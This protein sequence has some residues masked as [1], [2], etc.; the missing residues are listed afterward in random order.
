MTEQKD[1]KRIF[2]L[3]EERPA[4][5]IT[6][7][8]LPL[9]CGMF[10]MVLYNLVDTFFI[11]LLHDD[12]QMAAVNLAY[13]VMMIS[14]AVS[15]MVGAGASSLISRS[16]G[17]GDYEKASHT[18]TAGFVLTVAG[19]C[20]IPDHFQYSLDL[21]PLFVLWGM[22]AWAFLSRHPRKISPKVARV[23]RWV[24]RYSFLV[25]MIHYTVLFDLVWKW[26]PSVKL[27]TGSFLLHT[28]LTLVISLAA[29]FLL[30][31]VLIYPLQCLCRKAL[32]IKPKK[33]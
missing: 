17:A 29:A 19:R 20:L 18:V 16:M 28:C 2:I 1:H 26:I 21:S 7:L 27:A 23:L 4:K 32:G 33:E 12:Y 13:P 31:R 6:K 9:A 25:Y 10:I 11:G 3:S 5:A 8:G 30:D 15:N 22:G 24:A 14:I